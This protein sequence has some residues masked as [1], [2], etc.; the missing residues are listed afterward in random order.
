MSEYLEKLRKK[1]RNPDLPEIERKRILVELGNEGEEVANNSQEVS[2][3]KY[4]V[5]SQGKDE[6][7]SECEN[8]IEDG[9]DIEELIKKRDSLKKLIGKVDDPEVENRIVEIE[10]IIEKYQ[11]PSIKY[12]EN[13][14]PDPLLIEGEVSERW[15][16]NFGPFV[17][18]KTNKKLIFDDGVVYTEAEVRQLASKAK[19]HPLSQVEFDLKRYMNAE[20]M[21]GKYEK[22]DNRIGVKNI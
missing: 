2:S 20:V 11:E 15:D 1:L 4:Q 8:L 21:V 6:I 7:S 9:I 22:R 10:G 18:D 14:P 12:Q 13:T 3:I 5:S 17:W 16:S 19:G